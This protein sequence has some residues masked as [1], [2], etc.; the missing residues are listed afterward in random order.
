MTCATV[1][2]LANRTAL[3]TGAARGIGYAIAERLAA[4]G[5]AVIVADILEAEGE[6]AVAKLT[7]K[8]YAAR[9]LR[10]DVADEASWQA[11]LGAIAEVEGGV[12]IL[13]NNAGIE[14]TTLMT[15][16]DIDAFRRLIDVNL[17]G[18]ALG[19][20]HGLRAMA[21]KGGAIVNLSSMAAQLSTPATGPYAAT[22]SAVERLTRIA[23]AEAGKL[24][25]G[26]RVNCVL[27]GFVPTALSAQSTQTA[28]ELGLF[29]DAEAMQ[30]F[31]NEAIPMGRLGQPE[32]IAEAVLFLASESASYVTGASLPVA[33]GLGA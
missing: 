20:K 3:V 10:L 8:G 18:V 21:G 13:V 16:L 15:D 1:T 24:K 26:V 14:I 29:P 11:A 4:A 7:G 17:V 22:K 25:T 9:F 33:G 5:A 31:L 30:G 2:A 28:L 23:A 32:E 6:K 12:D 19:L 27:P